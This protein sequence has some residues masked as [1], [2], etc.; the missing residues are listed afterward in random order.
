MGGHKGFNVDIM[1]KLLQ[2]NSTQMERPAFFLVLFFPSKKG[3]SA[4]QLLD[5]TCACFSV[6]MEEDAC[7]FHFTLLF[8]WS[9]WCNIF[10]SIIFQTSLAL[11]PPFLNIACV[12]RSVWPQQKWS[13]HFLVHFFFA[14]LCPLLLFSFSVCHLRNLS[15]LC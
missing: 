2:I 5:S 9:N 7:D 4:L 12:F 15:L 10:T 8:K 3:I 6:R 11:I 13:I 14:S 1:E